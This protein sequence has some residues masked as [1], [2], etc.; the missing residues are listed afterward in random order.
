MSAFDREAQKRAAAARAVAEVESGMVLG[1]GSGSTAELALAALAE[2]IAAGL[3][4]CGIP[5][6]ERTA[7]LARRLGVPLTGFAEYRR[8]DLAIDGADQVARAGLALIK[9]RGGSLLRE[10][11]VA[12]ASRRM[13]V[14]AD[15]SKLVD[16][17][18]GSTPLAVEIVP[19]GCEVT[20]ERLA[21]L[22]G[23][24]ALRRRG[25]DPFVTD[26]GNFIADCRFTSLDEPE[27][28]EASLDRIVGVVACG[29]FLGLASSAFI[30]GRHGVEELTS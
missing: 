28:L 19:F 21:A 8:I 1:L 29:L 9:G 22:G 16:R 24:P 7:A 4:I 11:I 13:I 25:E 10:K 6:S 2:R 23:D 27:Q 12:K 5:S 20:L 14:V 26:N 17:L 30:G 18:G 3:S 15:E